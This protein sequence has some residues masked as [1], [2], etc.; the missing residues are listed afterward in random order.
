MAFV[1]F[2]SLVIYMLIALGCVLIA[3]RHLMLGIA[4]LLLL[5]IPIEV[6]LRWSIYLLTQ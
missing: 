2:T 5:L 3:A 6:V 4:G 1:P